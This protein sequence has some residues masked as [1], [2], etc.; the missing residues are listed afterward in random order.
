MPTRNEIAARLR[1]FVGNELLDGEFAGLDD[2]TPLL[3][4]GLINSLSIVRLQSFLNKQYGLTLRAGDLSPDNLRTL[5]ILADV[6]ERF[7][8]DPKRVQGA[9]LPPL[10]TRWAGENVPLANAQWPYWLMHQVRP[11]DTL[12]NETCGVWVTGKLDT[13]AMIA[14]IRAVVGRHAALRARFPSD[15]VQAFG[16]VEID[17]PVVEIGAIDQRDRPTLLTDISPD[18]HKQPF[19]LSRGPLFRFSLLHTRDD[20]HVLLFTAHHIIFDA[21]SWPLIVADI[22]AAYTGAAAPTPPQFPDYVLW[23]KEWRTDALVKKETGYWDARLGGDIPL[24]ALPTDWP[25]EALPVSETTGWVVPERPLT[26]AAVV[27]A[28]VRRKLEELGLEHKATL[29]H[30]A[31][32]AF[33]ALLR[34][35]TK[36]TDLWLGVMTANRGVAGTQGMVGQLADMTIVRA[37]VSGARRAGDLIQKAKDGSAAALEHSAI[38]FHELLASTRQR[39]AGGKRP[40]VSAV[41]NYIDGW[42]PVVKAGAVELGMIEAN[43]PTGADLFVRVFPRKDDLMLRVT[44]SEPLLKPETL[45]R[46]LARYVEL[47]TV[48]A[49]EGDFPA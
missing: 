38:G 21:R 14:A 28:A 46:I 27:P 48:V 36:Q 13:S 33:T 30:V 49:E 12:I 11:D 26:D 32:A 19:D 18:R 4:Y 34:L 43:P 45:R 44:S 3:E 25:R 2:T 8:G 35:E 16:D 42:Q 20:E 6:V 22:A 9:R 7:L 17:V 24:L 15:G 41:L 23:E 5:G 39:R 47:L 10:R 37:D 31:L 40:L 1:E 29:F